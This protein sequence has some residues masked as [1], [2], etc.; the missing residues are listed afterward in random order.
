[1]CLDRAVSGVDV[2][3]VSKPAVSEKSDHYPI[4][5]KPHWLDFCFPPTCL[6]PMFG[7]IC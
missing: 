5:I 7:F 4:M 6:M 1:M 2:Q 3:L